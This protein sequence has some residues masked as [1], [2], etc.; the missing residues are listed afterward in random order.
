MSQLTIAYRPKKF[1]HVVGQRAALRVLDGFLT[2]DRVPGTLLLS[3]PRGVG[4][5]TLARIL[6][7]RLNCSKP[8]GVEPCGT[9]D[10]CKAENHPDILEL[11]AASDR[12][13]DTVRGLEQL[14]ML[15]PTYRRR[16]IVMDEAHALTPSAGQA[17]LKTLEE[18]PPTVCFI[19]VTTDPDKLPDTVLS[20]CSKITLSKVAE[21]VIVKRLGKIAEREGVS[22]S[23]KALTRIAEA[24]DGHPREALMLLE[25]VLP[26]AE[27]AED[28]DAVVQQ[29]VGR[30]PQNV[31]LEFCKPFLACDGKG[32]LALVSRLDDSELEGFFVRALDMLDG[33]CV[34]LVTEKPFPHPKIAKLKPKGE[35]F[36]ESVFQGLEDFSEWYYAAKVGRLAWRH[37]LNHAIIKYCLG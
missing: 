7:R 24:S 21:P 2:K 25:Q 32:A 22:L 14:S 3:G 16:V 1:S 37:A 30:V 13:I 34:A 6:A 36:L 15:A 33:W 11:N 20:R 9:C 8:E 17:L 28:L 29:V 12:G 10:S 18:A 23:D 35:A 27:N 31:F 19:M 5:T 26:L 4:K